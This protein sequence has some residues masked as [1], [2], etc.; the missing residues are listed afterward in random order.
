MLGFDPEFE[1]TTYKTVRLSI[2]FDDI[3]SEEWRADLFYSNAFYQQKNS[4]LLNPKLTSLV[5]KKENS[6]EMPLNQQL[7]NHTITNIRLILNF[8]SR[9]IKK[10]LISTEE[11]KRDM[12]SES[13]MHI[14]MG[15]FR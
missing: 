12:L 6:S 4:G 5:Y 10:S 1:H 14:S 2:C 3:T 9:I 11:A 15:S 8:S 13:M 7:Q